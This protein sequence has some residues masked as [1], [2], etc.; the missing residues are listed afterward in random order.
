MS[1]RIQFKHQHQRTV[2]KMYTE[3]RIISYQSVTDRTEDIIKFVTL[4]HQAVLYQQT[5]LSVHTAT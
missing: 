5:C 3:I 4:L 1:I 2:N